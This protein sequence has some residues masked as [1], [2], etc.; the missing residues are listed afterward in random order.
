VRVWGFTLTRRD[1]DKPRIVLETSHQT[2]E[3]PEDQWFGERA[4]T[5]WPSPE[6]SVELD[7]GLHSQWVHDQMGRE[8]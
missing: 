2:V 3:L 4:S 7:P 8:P 1:I 6:W 5:Q